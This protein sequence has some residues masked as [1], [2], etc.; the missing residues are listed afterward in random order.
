MFECDKNRSRCA[1][2]LT[3]TLTMAPIYAFRLTSRDE[4]HRA[5]QAAAFELVGCAAHHLDPS[6]FQIAFSLQ[7]V[8]DRLDQPL[9]GLLRIPERFTL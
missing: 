1:A 2:M 8:D 4:T 6:R 7:E 3:A 5:A 9:R